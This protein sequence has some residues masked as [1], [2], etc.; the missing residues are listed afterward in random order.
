M[1]LFLDFDGVLH[2]SEVFLVDGAPELRWSQDPELKL[3]CWA[4]ILE[5]VLAECDPAGLIEIVLSTSW[6]HKLGKERAAS[7]LPESLRKRVIGGTF[8]LAIPRGW[9]VALQAEESDIGEWIAIDDSTRSWPKAYRNRLVDCDPSL[10]LS[11]PATV[12]K[13][14]AMLQ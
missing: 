2:P 12:S 7:Y 9:E 3:F 14:K 11:D 1:V 10:G 6:G 5:T 13:L 8:D 4:G